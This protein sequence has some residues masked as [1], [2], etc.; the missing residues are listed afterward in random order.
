MHIISK[1]NHSSIAIAKFQLY[2]NKQVFYVKTS[3]EMRLRKTK[4]FSYKLLNCILIIFAC[5]TLAN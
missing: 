4:A 1:K 5:Y 3:T 2:I